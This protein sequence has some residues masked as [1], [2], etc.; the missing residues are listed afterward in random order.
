M[1]DLK[2]LQRRA[3][4]IQQR[5]AELN[6][7]QGHNQW[8]AKDY[9]MG[10]AGDFGDL[11]KLVMAKEKMRHIDDVDAKLKHEL[12]DCLWSLLVLAENYEIDLE[13]EFQET[14]KELESRIAGA[15]K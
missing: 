4:E 5:Y 13:A 3:R 14:M 1:S 10:F 2:D 12:A 11:M 9:A 6:M 15:L 7:K 8:K